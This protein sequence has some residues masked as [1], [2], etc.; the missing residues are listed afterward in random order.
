MKQF[1]EQIDIEECIFDLDGGSII[2]SCIDKDKNRYSILLNRSMMDEKNPDKYNRI[3]VNDQ[4]IERKSKLE[5]LIK[6]ALKNAI[7][8]KNE[9]PTKTKINQETALIIGDDIKENLDA[10]EQ[11]SDVFMMKLVNDVI[12]SIE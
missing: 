8:K 2:L 10:L 3:Y 7:I 5:L 1:P 4:K 12:K 11:N 9:L 6:N